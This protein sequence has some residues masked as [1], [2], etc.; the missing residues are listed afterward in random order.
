M[1]VCV[2]IYIVYIYIYIYYFKVCVGRGGGGSDSLLVCL[3]ITILCYMTTK[4]NK[5]LRIYLMIKWL[6]QN[7]EMSTFKKNAL[8]HCCKLG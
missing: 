2:Y 1:C 4:N 3:H 5:H 7:I 8:H 6:Q